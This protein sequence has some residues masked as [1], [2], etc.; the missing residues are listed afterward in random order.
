MHELAICESIREEIE[1]QAKLQCFLRV[2]RVALE[3]GALAGVEIESLQFG[4][5]VV[6]RGSPAETAKLD[7]IERPA[8][9]WCFPCETT[10]P[11]SARY[12][13]CPKCGS[14]QLQ[15]TA[16]EELKIKELEVD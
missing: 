12:H 14:Y 8:R 16:G 15:V 1:K 3:I 11:I 7:I 13:P 9:A 10:V 6:M 2:R 5:D 4:F